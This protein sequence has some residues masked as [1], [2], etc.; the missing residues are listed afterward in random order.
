[1]DVVDSEYHDAGKWEQGLTEALQNEG[2]FNTVYHSNIDKEKIDILIS[3]EVGG[4]FQHNGAKNFFTWWP[5][6][7]ILA[8]GWR[9]TRYTYDAYA[10]VKLIDVH[11]GEILGEYHAD[12]SHIL[13]HRSYGPGPVLGALVFVPGIIKGSVSA[14]P[15]AQYRQQIYEVAYPNLW[16]KIAVRIA[17]DQSKKYS[18][19]MSSLKVQCGEHLD[20]AP[21]IGMVWSEFV[22]CQTQTYRLL[23]K[24][25]MDSGVV[26]VYVSNDRHYRLH[27]ATDGR[28]VR[29]YILKQHK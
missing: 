28:I 3:G 29:W 1:M 22:T 7:I 8:H 12:S 17:E 24:E 20:E 18:Q 6:A 19:K 25:A 26:T 5:G 16:K 2:V 11:T 15:R 4:S 27:V 13:I 9:G 23:G 14:S 21:K 10:D